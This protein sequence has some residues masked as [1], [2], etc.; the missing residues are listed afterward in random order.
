MVILVLILRVGIGNVPT[1]S[2]CLL[3]MT[4]LDK[5]I[6]KKNNVDLWDI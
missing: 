2:G 4:Y 6:G 1:E 5:D 3:P